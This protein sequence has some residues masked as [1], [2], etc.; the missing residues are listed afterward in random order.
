MT[1]SYKYTTICVNYGENHSV[2]YK[3][4]K[5]INDVNKETRNEREIQETPKPNYSQQGWV[6]Y[7]PTH[8]Q[9]QV[10]HIVFLKIP[11]QINNPLSG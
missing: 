10:I 4:C 6:P 9:L 3:R 5:Y 11:S 7:D 8:K 1:K 2:N